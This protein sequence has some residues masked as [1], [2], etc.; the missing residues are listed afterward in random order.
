LFRIEAEQWAASAKLRS[1]AALQESANKAKAIIVE[2][3]A[4]AKVYDQV[5]QKREFD[6]QYQSLKVSCPFSFIWREIQ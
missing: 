3:E 1:E 6:I 4:E 2:A 5:A